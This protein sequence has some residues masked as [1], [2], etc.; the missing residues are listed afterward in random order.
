MEV[1]AGDPS[2]AGQRSIDKQ[3]DSLKQTSDFGFIFPVFSDG[4]AAGRFMGGQ[5]GRAVFPNRRD[6]CFPIKKED[7]RRD[8]QSCSIKKFE[9]QMDA[10]EH[11]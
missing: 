9:P 6:A 5:A 8:F 1:M 11:R 7:D 3:S 10:D 2:G 4:L